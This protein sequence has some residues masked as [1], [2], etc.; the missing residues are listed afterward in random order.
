MFQKKSACFKTIQRAE[1]SQS[2]CTQVTSTWSR[3]RIWPALPNAD[4]NIAINLLNNPSC[5]CPYQVCIF[6]GW[7][8]TSRIWASPRWLSLSRDGRPHLFTQQC[9]ILALK[10]SLNTNEP[11][12][13]Y[14]EVDG[15]V[16]NFLFAGPQRVPLFYF[17]AQLHI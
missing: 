5:Y 2:E 16:L 7:E 3:D 12:L 14:F 13:K 17:H 9:Y 4:Q 8:N 11:Q 10:N 15:L 1:F 6:N